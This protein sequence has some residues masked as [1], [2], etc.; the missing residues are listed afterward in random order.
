MLAVFAMNVATPSTTLD[1]LAELPNFK[2]GFH[3]R[4][5]LRHTGI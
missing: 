5:E 4:C 2:V 1:Q 3:H